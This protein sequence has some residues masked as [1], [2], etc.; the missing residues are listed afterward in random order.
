MKLS[1]SLDDNLVQRID[2]FSKGNSISRSGFLAMA[3]TQYL[4]QMQAI[5]SMPEILQIIKTSASNGMTAKK[6]DIEKLSEFESQCNMALQPK[7]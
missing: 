1:I 6:E 5:S 3:A 4:N 7:K 2:S